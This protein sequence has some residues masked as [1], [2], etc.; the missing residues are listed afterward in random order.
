MDRVLYYIILYY[1]PN[2]LGLCLD[3]VVG[4]GLLVGGSEP[5]IASS[6]VWGA[7]VMYK[8]CS[9]HPGYSQI[10]LFFE[11]YIKSSQGGQ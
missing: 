3:S 4:S 10:L 1:N 9:T 5:S 6:G 8:L 2:I 11:V 7:P